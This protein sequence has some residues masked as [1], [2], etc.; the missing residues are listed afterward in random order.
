MARPAPRDYLNRLTA[1]LELQQRH[2]KRFD[3]YYSGTRRLDLIESEYREVFGTHPQA[4]D[5][6]ALT[7]PDTNVTAVGCHALAERIQLETFTSTR[8]ASGFLTGA[9]SADRSSQSDQ[10]GSPADDQDTEAEDACRAIWMGSD[11]DVMQS[12]AVLESLV[13]GRSFLL[14]TRGPDGVV[15]SVEDC[16]QV[17]VLRSVEPPYDVVAAVK[18]YP[19]PWGGPDLGKLW[20]FDGVAD[21]VMGDGG[22]RIGEFAAHGLDLPPVTELAYRQRLLAEPRSYIEPVASLADSYAVLMAYLVIAAR[23]GAIPVRTM[24]GITLPRTKSGLILPFGADPENPDRRVPISSHRALASES[25]DA[26]FS[27]LDAGQLS[28][29][30]GAVDMILNSVTAIMRVPQHYFGRGATSGTSGEM[31][32]SSEAGLT[33]RSDDVK[34]YLGS[35]FRKHASQATTME[36]GRQVLLHPTWA[37][38]E[39]MIDAQQADAAGKYVTAGVPLSVALT[40]VGWPALLIDQATELAAANPDAGAELGEQLGISGVQD[41][42]G[43]Q[44]GQQVPNGQGTVL[45]VPGA[46]QGLAG[47]SPA[48][49]VPGTA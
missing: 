16:E 26:R 41:P 34:R 25:P 12:V 43:G 33:R 40:K 27:Q 46:R 29:F 18:V 37:N 47:A 28:E 30:I 48:P 42:E 38:T 44:G 24:S 8:P 2:A 17:A 45:V 32:K 1:Q 20:L 5:L 9:P 31:L 3:A 14:N 4:R 23:F 39:T 10:P 21:L 6:L 35:G 13:K 15:M 49:Y 19:D 11:M 7:P 22:W 36:L